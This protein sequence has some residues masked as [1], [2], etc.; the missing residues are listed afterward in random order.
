MRETSG[1]GEGRLVA[2]V[3]WLIPLAAVAAGMH[4]WLPKMASEHGA[5]IDR[6]LHYLLI[7]VGGLFVT[8]HVVFGYFL[9]RFSGARRAAFRLP[10]V[11]TERKWSLIPIIALSLIAE[12]GVFVLGL[13]VWAKLYAAAPPADAVFVE[14][15]AEQFAWNVRYPGADGKFG[16]TLTQLLSLSNPL[17][18]DRE[19]LAA[20]DDIVLLSEIYLPVN[21]PARIR[22]RSKDVL[23]SFFLPH[24]RIKQDIVP[25]MTIETRFVPTETGTYEIACAELCG[26]GHYQMRGLVHVVSEEEFNQWLSEQ[27]PYF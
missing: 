24:Q 15:T 10:S 6:M 5:G 25:G 18:L 8:G 1:R 9:W 23:H 2:V 16:R 12:G 26:F 13:P 11:R 19:D 4:H 17:G 27:S 14:V 7:T 22:L 21:R 20:R 3:M